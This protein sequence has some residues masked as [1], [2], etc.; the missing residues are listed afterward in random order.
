MFKADMIL[1][2]DDFGE[3]GNMPA[4]VTAIDPEKD[5][6]VFHF[7]DTLVEGRLLSKG[8]TE[9]LVMGSWLAE[10]IGAKVGYWVTLVT[11]ETEGFLRR[12]T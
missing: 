4:L 1:Y 12:L 11:R 5:N 7:A 9:S 10:D 2:S 8:D 3:D 6:E